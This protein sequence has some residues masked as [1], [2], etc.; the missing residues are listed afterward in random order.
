M[1]ELLK[2]TQIEG[3]FT[4]HSLHCTGMTRLFRSGVDRKLVKEFTGHVSDA[5]DSYQ[6]TS[7]EQREHMSKIITSG[8]IVEQQKIKESTGEVELKVTNNC[9]NSGMSC[10]CSK[11][12][13]KFAEANRL[14]EVIS[15]IV[16]KRKGL[17]TK[18]KLEIE[19]CE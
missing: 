13:V 15:N 8:G 16:E 5:V 19:F 11:Q 7:D 14:G 18:I 12:N 6:I 9:A 10:S 1:K 17:K 2:G 3:F 4:N